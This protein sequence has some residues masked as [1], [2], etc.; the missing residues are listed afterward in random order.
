M[1]FSPF[2]RDHWFPLFLSW[3]QTEGNTLCSRCP[4]FYPSS[5]SHASILYGEQAHHYFA[6]FENERE[7]E[8]LS[9]VP[10]GPTMVLCTWYGKRTL[11]VPLSLILPSRERKKGRRRRGWLIIELL[12]FLSLPPSPCLK[13]AK[14]ES[15][16]HFFLPLLSPPILFFCVPYI[17]KYI[18]VGWGQMHLMLCS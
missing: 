5:T 18:T 3:Y 6:Y 14:Q 4:P 10:S 2:V 13:F 15:S 8:P 17:V 7:K 1:L 11:L 12:L 16:F 9:T